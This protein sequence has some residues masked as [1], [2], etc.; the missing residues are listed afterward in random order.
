MRG[1][2]AD[3]QADTGSA[4]DAVRAV[5][6]AIIGGIRSQGSGGAHSSTQSP[7]TPTRPTPS[8]RPFCAPGV[9]SRHRHKPVG[10][11]IGDTPADADARHLVM[12][13][14]S[15]MAAGCLFDP[16]LISDISLRGV[17]GIVQS[18]MQAPTPVG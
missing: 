5:A 7:S 13:R 10:A 2:L 6:K 3:A 11:G 14:D 4:V 15:A 12:L 8:T 16:A 1:Q 17:E 18:R 9:V